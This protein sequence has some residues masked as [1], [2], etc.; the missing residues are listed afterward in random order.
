MGLRERLSPLSFLLSYTQ[1]WV[2]GFISIIYV[3]YHLNV[4]AFMDSE[5]IAMKSENF[6]INHFPLCKTSHVPGLLT[7]RSLSLG[8]R[9]SFSPQWV[10]LMKDFSRLILSTL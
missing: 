2:K 9:I 7:H 3:D 1:P 5:K 4:W 8:Y 10:P 6:F